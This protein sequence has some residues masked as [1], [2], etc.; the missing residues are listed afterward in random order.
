MIIIYGKVY[1]LRTISS[2]QLEIFIS[3]YF[4]IVSINI[5][6]KF[7]NIIPMWYVH[8]L[9]HIVYIMNSSSKM[10]I[11]YFT[12]AISTLWFVWIPKSICL[13]LWDIL[14]VSAKNFTWLLFSIYILS[15]LCAVIKIFQNSVR[16]YIE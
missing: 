16:M 2:F 5:V 11:I 3:F 4:V 7:Q 1:Y 9:Y 8:Y 6:I 10:Y 12:C 13:K 15:L 14:V